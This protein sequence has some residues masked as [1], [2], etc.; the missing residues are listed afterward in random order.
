MTNNTSHQSIEALPQDQKLITKPNL[1]RALDMT[2]SG[3]DKLLKND[4]SFPR[5]LKFSDSQQATC[6]FPVG[7]VNAWLETKLAER[8]AA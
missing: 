3:I 2:R 5:P 4:P 7:E 8:G 6:Y 1:C